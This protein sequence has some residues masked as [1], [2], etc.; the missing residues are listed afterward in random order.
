MKQCKQEVNSLPLDI[1]VRKIGITHCKFTGHR[2]NS[3]GL[4]PIIYPVFAQSARESVSNV[5]QLIHSQKLWLEFD[6]YKNVLDL[7]FF[8]CFS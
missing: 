3:Y 1:G 2:Y 7:S 8:K 6:F 4:S 5:F